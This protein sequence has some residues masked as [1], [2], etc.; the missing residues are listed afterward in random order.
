MSTAQVTNPKQEATHKPKKIAS[1]QFA[2]KRLMSIHWI[3]ATSYLILFM[4]GTTIFTLGENNYPIALLDFHVSMGLLVIGLLTYRTLTLLQVSW[5]KY[6]QRSPKFTPKWFGI[7]A[8]HSSLYLFMWAVP[9]TGVFLANTAGSDSVK[10]FGLP[11]PDVFPAN[12][13]LVT[14]AG[15]LHFWFAYTFLAFIFLHMGVQHKT[16]QKA[17]RNGFRLISRSGT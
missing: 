4:T 13:A 5:Q 9:V 10:F 11:V 15:N 1:L 12:E 6:S 3:M 17:W 14:F 2:L 16:L 8:L 7:T